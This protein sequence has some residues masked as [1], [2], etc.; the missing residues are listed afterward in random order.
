M[1][2]AMIQPVKIRAPLTAEE[3]LAV[4]LDAACLVERC[5]LGA[6]FS[7]VLGEEQLQVVD[8]VAR[9]AGVEAHAVPDLPG[10]VTPFTVICVYP[11]SGVDV[12]VQ[13]HRTKQPAVL[14]GAS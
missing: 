7:Y 3:I 4:L 6:R 12:L 10:Y 13:S 14:G 11:F 5:G 1:G 9:L 2:A 8:E